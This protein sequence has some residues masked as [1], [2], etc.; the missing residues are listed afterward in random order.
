MPNR[1]DRLLF[2]PAITTQSTHYIT[3]SAQMWSQT[4]QLQPAFW[5][6]HPSWHT[7][8]PPAHDHDCTDVNVSVLWLETGGLYDLCIMHIFCGRLFS[9]EMCKDFCLLMTAYFDQ[10][11]KD[12]LIPHNQSFIQTIFPL[13]GC[14]CNSAVEHLPGACKVLGSSPITTKE[15]MRQW[16]CRNCTWLQELCMLFGS[17]EAGSLDSQ[18]VNQKPGS[19]ITWTQILAAGV[20]ESFLMY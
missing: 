16:V 18:W 11:K 15:R 2:I 17:V 1:K 9:F 10:E 4:S 19:G 3:R 7:I 14:D 8:R 5:H 6:L 12:H 20:G 13:L